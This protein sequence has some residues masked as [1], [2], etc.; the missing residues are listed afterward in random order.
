[1]SDGETSMDAGPVID[2]SGVT[3][4]YE[5]LLFSRAFGCRPTPILVDVRSP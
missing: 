1:M 4:V 5:M 3:K 2:V